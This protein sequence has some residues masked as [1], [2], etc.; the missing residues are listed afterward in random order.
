MTAKSTTTPTNSTTTTSSTR[1]ER[2]AKIADMPLMTAAVLFL[3]AYAIPIIDV[4]LGQPWAGICRTITWITWVAFVIDY[5]VRLALAD[6]RWRYF[7]RHWLDLLIIALPLLRPLRL[8]RLVTLLA[9]INRRAT[10]GLRGRIAIYVTGGALLLGFCAS[11][12]VLNAER[13]APGSNITSFGDAEWWAITTMTT[14]GYGDVFPVTTTGRFVAAGLM[15]G[16]VAILGM[17]TATLASWL[18]EHV[19]SEEDQ[20]TDTLSQQIDRLSGQVERL[21]ARLDELG[22]LRPTDAV[23][24]PTEMGQE[25]GVDAGDRHG[26]I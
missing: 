15:I 19:A 16:G 8:L 11:L 24:S 22:E 7:L 3:A 12:A 20:Q 23:T 26:R 4:K 21:Q 14:V 13:S 2:W 1:V 10:T 17:V 18:V 9:V 25:L 6:H 5:V